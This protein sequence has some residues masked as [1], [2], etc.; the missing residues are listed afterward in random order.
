[1]E[2]E[3]RREDSYCSYLCIPYNFFHDIIRSFLVRF[4]VLQTPPD[5]F[6]IAEE[7]EEETE[8]VKVSSRSVA[9]KKVGAR[10]NKQQTSSGKR[11]GTNKT[12]S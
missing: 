9:S 4:H 12:H 1:M 8:A 3:G 2:G 6:P 7:K 5:N 11:G 10:Q